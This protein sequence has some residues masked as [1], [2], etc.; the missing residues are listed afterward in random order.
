MPSVNLAPLENPETKDPRTSPSW[1]VIPNSA[2]APHPLAIKDPLALRDLMVQLATLV[3]Q[4][5]MASPET[6]DLVDPVVK[7]ANLALPVKRVLLA[8]LAMLS[9]RWALLVQS[10]V[11]DTPE[12]LVPLA[13]L[14][15][16][17]R[18]VDLVKLVPLA[19]LDP[20]ATLAS[21][22]QLVPMEM[23][24]SKETPEAAHT[25]HRLVWP[26]AIK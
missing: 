24:A 20:M 16:P 12:L 5:P 9:P 15:V 26:Q 4:V 10:V 23:L 2:H 25:A 11:L 3:P 6:R 19:N 14:A 17:E 1:T 22:A 13:N 21:L 18:M 7:L 8:A